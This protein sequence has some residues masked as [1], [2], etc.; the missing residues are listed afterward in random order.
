LK[1]KIQTSFHFLSIIMMISSLR[2]FSNRT[3]WLAGVF[4]LLLLGT[5]Y[6]SSIGYLVHIWIANENFSHC[7]FIPVI[8]FYLIWKKRETL[9]KMDL[10][11]SW[12]GLPVVLAGSG[13]YLVGELAT[14]Y[15]LIHLSLLVVLTGLL[16]SAIGWRGLREIAFP[17]AFLFTMI[18]PPE[19]LLITL[20]SQL[21]LISSQMAVGFDQLIGVMA[22]REGNVIDFGTIQLQVVEACSGLRYLFPM[23]TFALILAYLFQDKLWRRTLIFLSSFPISIF[24]NGFRI[25]MTGLL[26]DRFG[27]G[28]AEGFFHAFSGWLLFVTGLSIL[29]LELALFGNL[30]SKKNQKSFYDLF[31]RPT[32]QNNGNLPFLS[33]NKISLSIPYLF[34]LGFLLPLVVAS[35]FIVSRNES[36]P[37]RHP[38]IDFPM[39]LS[40]WEGKPH[41]MESDYI[42]FLKFDDYI[43]ADFRSEEGAPINFYSAWYN[44]QKKGQ[45]SHS[46]RT[47]IPGGGW[48]MT[49]LT[50]MKVS[51]QG[52]RPLIVNRAIIQKGEQKEV[53]YYWFQQRG[54]VMTNEYL[55]KFYLLW[56]ALTKNRTDGALVRLVSAVYPGEN[57]AAVDHRMTIFTENL[58]PLLGKYIPD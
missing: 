51:D 1:G 8:S 46:P 11:G 10:K 31:H 16:L 9:S 45:S 25:G 6:A 21:Q 2:L 27:E 3:F 56:D 15:T 55:V 28:P 35:F 22:F 17:V 36:V 50:Q 37:D 20:S 39:A 40:G 29:F 12:W 38:F 54:R 23:A 18:P 57:E 41:K 26:V 53:V 24:L 42:E 19:F 13:L 48:E 33:V 43:L 30:F 5:V 47:C 4:P 34:S 49:S 52:S 44:S 7:F 14:L 32:A 58:Q